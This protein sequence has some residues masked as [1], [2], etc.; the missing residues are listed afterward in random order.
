M[1]NAKPS[2][3]I[4]IE[5]GLG[6]T[7]PQCVGRKSSGAPKGNRNASKASFASTLLGIARGDVLPLAGFCTVRPRGEPAREAHGR[8]S[9]QACDP[10]ERQDHRRG[11]KP[12]AR[13]IIKLDGIIAREAD[14]QCRDRRGR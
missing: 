2:P 11:P 5:C 6:F 7:A 1:A 9:V 8:V 14:A 3:F 13:V 10:G 12:K 4:D